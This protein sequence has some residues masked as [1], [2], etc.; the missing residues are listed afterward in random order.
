MNN[1]HS[2]ARHI[3]W[4]VAGIKPRALTIRWTDRNGMACAGR[5]RSCLSCRLACRRA[6]AVRNRVRHGP[7]QRKRHDAE[8]SSA[9]AQV[10]RNAAPRRQYPVEMA[11]KSFVARVP[12]FGSCVPRSYPCAMCAPASNDFWRNDFPSVSLT[13]ISPHSAAFP[14]GQGRLGVQAVRAEISE[15]S[16][17]R[18]AHIGRQGATRAG[19]HPRQT[20]GDRNGT[21]LDPE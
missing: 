8:R 17:Y 21:D 16:E 2:S 1:G 9:T 20:T 4:A 18:A 19:N 6:E 14:A 15:I 10:R 13:S 12:G 7:C 5:L 3:C 11:H